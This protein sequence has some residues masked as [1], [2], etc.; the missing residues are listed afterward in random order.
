MLSYVWTRYGW[1]GVSLTVYDMSKNLNHVQP[2]SRALSTQPW[3]AV[4]MGMCRAECLW[5]EGRYRG[6]STLPE[7]ELGLGKAR[8]SHP[9]ACTP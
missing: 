9:W 7:R 3:V 4:K 6:F 2:F 8:G 1:R 5:Q